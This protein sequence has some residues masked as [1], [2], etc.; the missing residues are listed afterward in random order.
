MNRRWIVVVFVF[1]CLMMIG[2]GR[3]SASAAVITFQPPDYAV[4]YQ[5]VGQDGWQ[6]NTYGLVTGNPAQAFIAG[7]E[8]GAIDDGIGSLSI[9]GATGRLDVSKDAILSATADGTPAADVRVQYLHRNNATT[10]QNGVFVSNDAFHGTTSAWVRIEGTNIRGLSQGGFETIGSYTTGHVVE[11]SLAM[12]LDTQSYTVS[13]RDV[14]QGETDFT[15]L[16]PAPLSF[17]NAMQAGPVG[18]GISSDSSVNAI[19]D[20]LSVGP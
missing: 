7:G 14:T 6:L 15:L 10:G 1:A 17:Y 8:G 9:S 12:D 19:F 4:G 18:V 3:S 13:A 5:L 20:N 11:F 16:T 2:V